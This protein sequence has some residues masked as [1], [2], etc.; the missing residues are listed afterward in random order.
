M[1]DQHFLIVHEDPADGMDIEHPA[2]CPTETA[3]Y[4]MV[5]RHRC[6]VGVIEFDGEVDFHFRR[7]DE[8]VADWRGTYSEPVPVGR[9]PIEYWTETTRIQYG[10]DEFACGL[11]LAAG[12]ETMQ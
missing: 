3:Y 10:V 6:G 2:S 7:A 12:R 1:S 4:G 9:H 5:I 8:P 11:R